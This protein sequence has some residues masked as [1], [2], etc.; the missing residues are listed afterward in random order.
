MTLN[1]GYTPPL[2]CSIFMD[3]NGLYCHS[4]YAY[5]PTVGTV[6]LSREKSMT[7]NI[8]Y[9]PLVKC[10]IFMDNNRLYCHYSYA[11]TPTVGTVT[12]SRVLLHIYMGCDVTA[13]NSFDFISCCPSGRN[14][15][16]NVFCFSYS[17]SIAILFVCS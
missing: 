7:L 11:N 13:C 9:T 8:G 6:T 3:N 5:T 15:L 16:T 17:A 4:S 10:S 12:L 14:G 1:N 2:R